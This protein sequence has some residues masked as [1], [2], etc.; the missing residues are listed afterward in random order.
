MGYLLKNTSALINTK[1]TDAA[2]RK[3]SLGGFDISYFQIGDSE[4]TYNTLPS[5][6]NQRNSMV[7]DSIF[8]GQNTSSAPESNKQH[9]KY[10]YYVKGVSGGTY[11]LP[12]IESVT[13][14]VYNTASP[15]GFFTGNTVNND[16]IWSALTDSKY[17]VN[18]EYS[19]DIST[20]DGTN[21]IN[22]STNG[23]VNSSLR[24]P[25][26]GDFVMMLIKGVSNGDCDCFNTSTTGY[27]GTVTGQTCIIPEPSCYPILT[28]RVKE[29]CTPTTLKFDRNVPD[30]TSFAN[31]CYANLLF[32]PSGMTEIYDS[33][34]PMQHF[35]QSVINFESLCYTDEFDVKILNMNIPWSENPAGMSASLGYTDYSDF[36][37]VDYLGTKEYLG[38]A[39]NSGQTF[40]VDSNHPNE[41]TDTFINN[42]FGEKVFIE[43]EEQKAI[44]IIHYTNNTI[45]FFYGE[46]FAMQPHDPNAV[47]QTSGEG[48]N[49]K[50]HM[51]WLM[52]HKN[53]E[54]CYGQTF[55]VDP[56]DFDD[57]DLFQV[58]YIQSTK[59]GDMN[60][61]GIRYYHLW[62]DNPDPV[63]GVPNRIG[64]VFPDQQIIVIDDEEIIASLSY[65]SNRNWTLPA[66]KLS[67]VTPNTC[68]LP[69][70][71]SE[72]LLSA[73]TEYMYVTYRLTN[74]SA[75]TDSLHCNYY[76]KIPGPNQSC[77]TVVPQNIAVRFG[78]EFNCLNQIPVTADTCQMI[79]GFYGDKFE[80]ICQKVVGEGRPDPDDWKIIDMTDYLTGSTID[81]YI[82]QDGIT[83]NTFVISY[84]DYISA[85][86]YDLGGYIE[87]SDNSTVNGLNFGDEYFFYGNLETDIQATIYELRCLINLGEANFQT[88][89]NPGYVH[90]N[91]AYITEI[92]LY[93]SDKELMI[94]SKLQSPVLRQGIQQFL[95]KYDF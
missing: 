56:P 81:G 6:Y 90:G 70:Q 22:L 51:P 48:R 35:N 92:G 59:N 88:S 67:L 7:L 93:D 43:P 79:Q 69:N 33:V 57:L 53:P 65:K 9:V 3:L 8:N 49:F 4:V 61:P 58:R 2:R 75:F 64:K 13:S 32:Y 15:R 82:T 72:G 26:V 39:S 27:C 45:N 31:N 28:Y 73:N 47:S 91:P 36:G 17:V 23:C 52:W 89:S 71:S 14:P 29:V 16:I 80:V 63:T 21:I 40:F 86:Y 46:K 34:T 68:G 30:Y 38:Y 94:I 78:P 18:S 10:P 77:G 74:T 5:T 19:V 55:W 60:D 95:I 20:L 42:S 54:C 76:I 41:T 24:Q 50:L 62:D 11:G 12:Y 37:S 84:N 44:A 25:Q 87:L 83:G 66:P 1:I 85:S